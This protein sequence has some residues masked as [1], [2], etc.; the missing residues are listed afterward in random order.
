MQGGKMMSMCSV[1][2]RMLALALVAATGPGCGNEEPAQPAADAGSRPAGD[3]AATAADAPA[4]VP[5]PVKAPAPLIPIAAGSQHTCLVK[6][7]GEVYCWGRNLDSELGDGTAQN[8]P[9]PVPVKGLTGVKQVASEMFH[10]CAVLNDGQVWCWGRNEDGQLGSTA[11]RVAT[12]PV[13][14]EGVIDAIQVTTGADFSC[15]LHG[16]GTVSCWGNGA[17]GRLGQGHSKSSATPVE[18]AGLAAA[19][20]IAS[21]AQH[22]C[23]AT[24]GGEVYCWGS[25]AN[26]QAAL[27]GDMRESPRPVKVEGLAGIT[28]VAAG[29]NTTC[30][31]NEEGAL[32]CWGSN[33]YGQVG[34]GQE[35]TG[36]D[37]GTPFQV[38]GIQDVAQVDIGEYHTCAILR[39]GEAR[40]WGRDGYGNLGGAER[41][42][43]TS[44]TPVANVSDA[45]AVALGGHHVCVIRRS[46]AVAC[47]GRS[48]SGQLGA[49][50][51]SDPYHATDVIPS[52]GSLI[53]PPS[54][55]PTFPPDPAT[56]VQ[57][58]PMISTS[59]GFACAL[60]T[61]GQPLC[62]GSNSSGQ[63]GDGTTAY[64][65]GVVSD[66]SGIVD[67]VEV[68]V[69][70]SR[71]C[72]SR[73]NGTVACWGSL[74][75]FN[76]A[77]N[78][79]SSRPL[80]LE[81]V[82]DAV[83]VALGGYSYHTTCVRHASKAVSCMREGHMQPVEG[84][85]DVAQVVGGFGHA[86]ARLENGRVLCWGTGS[87]GRLGNG[88]DASS[89]A[90]VEVSGIRDAVQ[91]AAGNSFTCAL[92]RSGRVS[93]WGRDED[94][95]L[96]NGQSG[97]DVFSNR[98][99][100]VARLRDVA[101]VSAGM[102]HACALL[103]D[104]SVVCWGGNSF[105]QCGVAV[106]EGQ[107]T[108]EH[109]LQAT[110]VQP[111]QAPGYAQLGSIVALDCAWHVSCA[112]HETGGVSCW[113]TSA[114][115]GS[116]AL[117]GLVSERSPSPLPLAGVQLRPPGSVAPTGTPPNQEAAPPAGAATATPAPVAP[118]DVAAPGGPRPPAEPGS[119]EAPQTHRRSH[120]GSGRAP[121]AVPGDYGRRT[122]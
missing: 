103:R 8:R 3:A 24:Q 73:A 80:P 14:V 88:A 54:V 118:G 28:H 18:V 12:D 36:T 42:N 6:S 1:R 66:V 10:T 101:S 32:W 57:A 111:S 90:P 51:V 60:R 83:E 30:A 27:P 9:A 81:G 108:P 62:W 13:Q 53:T 115:L 109:V 15:A 65:R 85:S 56:P 72:A 76:G 55:A 91:L 45:S 46:G 67:A 87:E 97:E 37:V 52:V 95:E 82:T 26:K 25:N 117:G 58:E 71:A 112:L 106:A 96:G 79:R 5:P 61:D 48:E 29:S 105:N 40:C 23:A 17:N 89:D 49:E 78:V 33:S 116:G 47:W 113:G 22:T 7:S 120:I 77:K 119:P 110:P 100:D 21:G 68:R 16:S 102:N 93:C 2:A 19:R 59:E 64:R 39:S 107:E 98:P 86:C 121:T 38:P 43:R 104:G 44:P 84:L 50:E 75:L 69:G 122:H 4:Q 11:A 35:G 92:R 31:A 74:G 41:G 99:V 114:V 63:L 70:A 34:N 20:E 94:G